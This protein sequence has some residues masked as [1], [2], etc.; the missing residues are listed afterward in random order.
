[1]RFLVRTK[2]KEP[3][4]E[5]H[6]REVEPGNVKRTLAGVERVWRA[7]SSGNFYHTPSTMGCAGCGYPAACRG[8]QG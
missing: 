7:I 3:V 8:W 1:M 6:V 4:I 2:T 5:E